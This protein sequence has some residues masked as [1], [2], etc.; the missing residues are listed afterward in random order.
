MEIGQPAPG[1]QKFKKSVEIQFPADVQ[2]DLP[3]IVHAVEKYGVLFVV[4]KMGYLYVYEMSEA[5]LIFR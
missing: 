1:Q 5:V 3:M 4:T 2:G